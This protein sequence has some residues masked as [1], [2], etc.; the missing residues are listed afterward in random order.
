MGKRKTDHRTERRDTG[1]PKSVKLT[2]FQRHYELFLQIAAAVVVCF[3]FWLSVT[4]HMWAPENQM[5]RSDILPPLMTADLWLAILYGLAV[6][7]YVMISAAYLPKSFD[8]IKAAIKRYFSVDGL[9]LMA[10]FLWY[11]VCCVVL[12]RGTTRLVVGYWPFV[13]DMGICVLILFP[14]PGILGRQQTRKVLDWVLHAIMAFS[15]C[16]VLWALWHLFTLDIVKL[17]N[18]LSVGM[19]KGMT[20][21]MG[22]NTNIGAAIGTTMV[23]I[24]LYMISAHRRAV[25]WIYAAALLPHL[26]A[27]LLTNSRANFIALLVTLPMFVFLMIWH[28]GRKMA[29]WPRLLTGLAAGVAVALLF[30]FMRRWV[31]DLFEAVT[32]YSERLAAANSSIQA[33]K[34]AAAPLI[35]TEGLMRDTGRL[36]I[37][38]ASIRIMTSS[39]EKFFFG[40]P[41]GDYPALIQ[42]TMKEMF[43]YNASKAHAHNIILQ[44]GV[45]LGVPAMLAFIGYL[46]ITLLRCLR[47]GL[48]KTGGEMQGAWVLPLCILALII[49]NMF[50]PFIFLYFSAQGCLFCLFAG[51]VKALDKGET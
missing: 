13:M 10:L 49:V 31:F 3:H 35:A 25:R 38:P 39:V 19:D 40:T 17:P 36:K 12:G 44:V 22:T 29:L 4:R 6:L 26:L 15:T 43:K 16:F 18:G 27:V 51:W 5:F 48:R 28:S 32:H 47:V 21:Y 41:I 24:C 30:W 42:S 11:V 33:G 46:V 9:I 8:R 37:W 2:D 34:T 14:L 45:T 1:A 23:L 50:E 7:L 20:F